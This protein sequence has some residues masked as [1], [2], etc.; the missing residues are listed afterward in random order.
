MRTNLFFSVFN[1]GIT[2]ESQVWRQ[3]DKPLLIPSA[4]DVPIPP[5]LQDTDISRGNIRQVYSNVVAMDRQVGEILTQLEEDGLLD[6]T[7]IFW[8]TDHGGPLPRQKRLLYDSGIHV[9]L[10][11]RFPD[12]VRAGDIDDQLVS[13]VDFKSTALSLAGIEPPQYVDGRAFLGDYVNTPNRRYIHAAADRFDSEYDMIRAVRDARFKYLRNFNPEKPY[14]LPLAYRE[15]MPIM[16]ELLKLRDNEQLNE[17]QA[18][19]F[20]ASKDE[21]ELFDTLYDPHELVNLAKDPIHAEKLFEL[22][23]ELDE[24]VRLVDDKGLMSEGDLIVSMWPGGIQPI[25]STPVATKRRNNLEITLRSGTDGASI[26]YQILEEGESVNEAWTI[27]KEPVTIN[28]TQRLAA[29]A[30]R[31]GFAPSEIIT[32]R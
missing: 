24:W 30:H 22:R 6:S 17:A 13:F 12:G 19:W 15:Q 10:I 2:H 21:E 23:N 1:F 9:P 3:S 16:Q 8:Y 28:D 5:Y 31:L 4:L 7:V 25:T 20:R 18:Q 11:I 29:V 14:Y 32:I 27:Y 26:G